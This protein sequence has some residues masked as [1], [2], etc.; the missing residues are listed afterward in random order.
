MIHALGVG[1]DLTGKGVGS[2]MIRE[3]VRTA[4]KKGVSALRLDVP[5]TNEP[6]GNLY[7]RCGFVCRG[8]ERCFYD[9]TGWRIFQMYELLI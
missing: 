8:E 2:C 5:D 3:A 7:I 6:A 9:N 4:R 1:P